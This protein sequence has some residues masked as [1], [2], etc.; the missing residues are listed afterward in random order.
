MISQLHLEKLLIYE[1]L[2]LAL[3]GLFLYVRQWTAKALGFSFKLA[4]LPSGLLLAIGTY[5]AAWLLWFVMTQISGK[6]FTE[7]AAT[8]IALPGFKMMTVIAVSI[9]NPIFEELFVCAYAVSFV[10]RYR[11]R[12]V[13]VVISAALRFLYHLYQGVAGALSVLGVG[14]VFAA[15]FAWKKRAWPVVIAHGLLDLIALAPFIG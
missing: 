5:A 3:L 9:V 12:F 14:V 11:G 1:P 10:Q 15:Y 7:L 6:S 4:D 13:A 8:R 2:V